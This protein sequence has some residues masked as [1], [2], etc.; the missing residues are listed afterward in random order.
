MGLTVYIYYEK[1][2]KKKETKII[3]LHLRSPKVCTLK[4]NLLTGW[5]EYIIS[6]PKAVLFQHWAT[7][8]PSSLLQCPLNEGSTSIQVSTLHTWWHS[9]SSFSI[10]SQHLGP[11]TFLPPLG[12]DNCTSQVFPSHPCRPWSQTL[13]YSVQFLCSPPVCPCPCWSV[14]IFRPKSLFSL[15]LC[16]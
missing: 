9:S 14:G 4:T 10:H 13:S 1:K 3:I 11:V 5:G 8:L 6:V 15:S 16:L 2:K 7:F 12:L